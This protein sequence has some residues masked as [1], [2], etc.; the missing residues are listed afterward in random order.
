HGNAG[1][2]G[3]DQGQGQ[4]A[5]GDGAAEGGLF[6]LYFVDMDE[7]MIAGA[8]G[9]LVDALLVDQQPFGM[10]KVLADEGS[11]FGYGYGGHGVLHGDI[12]VGAPTSSDRVQ[13]W[14]QDGAARVNACALPL[15]C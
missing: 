5:V 7:L 9:K 14:W 8:F 3:G 6:G 13:P 15:V 10:A 4:E 11:Q 1:G 2:Q 12:V